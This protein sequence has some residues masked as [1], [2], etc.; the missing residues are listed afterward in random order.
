MK[1][2]KWLG[3]WFTYYDEAKASGKGISL[4]MVLV[5]VAA[6]SGIAV[7]YGWVDIGLTEEQIATIADYIYGLVILIV[8]WVRYDAT[9]PLMVRVKDVP[10]DTKQGDNDVDEHESSIL[11]RDD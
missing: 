3:K 2:L 9:K 4:S 10:D 11:D 5:A 1:A 7:N 6:F 8:G